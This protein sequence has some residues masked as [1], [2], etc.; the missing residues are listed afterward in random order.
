LLVSPF[1]LKRIVTRLKKKRKKIVFTN[2]CFDLLHAGH[3]RLLE[4]AK[5]LGEVLIVGLNS[6]RSA[7]KLKGLER[8]VVPEKERA[9][10]LSA[11]RAV[12]YVVLF[13]E[14][15]P[16]LLIQTLTPDVLVK[17]ADYAKA[18]NVGAEWV[19]AHVGKVIRFPFVKGKSSSKILAKLRRL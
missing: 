9:L 17:G 5:G 10:I 15:T 19:E 13:S 16:L 6:D 2:G 8:P 1:R 11:L 12:D 7:R 4:K 18:K 14:P 3:I